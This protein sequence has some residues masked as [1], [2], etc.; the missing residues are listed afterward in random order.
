[1]K[2]APLSDVPHESS[3]I[4]TTDDYPIEW[5]IQTDSLGKFK[6]AGS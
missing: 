3:R 5:K 2:G 1:M 4:L 6:G